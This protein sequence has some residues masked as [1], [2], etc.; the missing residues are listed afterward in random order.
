MKIISNLKNV[1]YGVKYF[2]VE[3]VSE[4]KEANLVT[5]APGSKVFVTNG[6]L[7][8]VLTRDREWVKEE[9]S[10]SGEDGATFIPHIDENKILSWTNDKDLPNPE[11]VDL[12][13]HDE[14]ST[15]PEEGIKT[16]Y[17]WTVLG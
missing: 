10:G 15:V 5:T 8:F 7:V 12:N 16:S 3:D 1:A 4:I 2:L 9:S 14:W 13:P 17:R 6:S 11:P